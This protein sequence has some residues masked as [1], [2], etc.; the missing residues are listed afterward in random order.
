MIPNKECRPPAV[1]NY[2]LATRPLF[3]RFLSRWEKPLCDW[4]KKEIERHAAERL[5]IVTPQWFICFKCAPTAC[6]K[7]YLCRPE[8]I[9][10]IQLRAAQ[11]D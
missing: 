11:E 8:S 1:S 3:L 10:K 4:S 6:G 2:F 5:T 7:H 9:E